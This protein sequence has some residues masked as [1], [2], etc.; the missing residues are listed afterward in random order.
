[1]VFTKKDFNPDRETCSRVLTWPK[2]PI[3]LAISN[4]FRAFLDRPTLP[5]R[6]DGHS[7]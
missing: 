2:Q 1:M 4:I 3:W 6:I 7:L 5:A